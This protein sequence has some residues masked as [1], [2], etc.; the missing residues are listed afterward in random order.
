M[1][2]DSRLTTRREDGTESY[3]DDF[4]KWTN[5]NSKLIVIASGNARLAC[6]LIGQIIG[7]LNS[8]ST[9]SDL[10]DILDNQLPVMAK[11]YY[12]RYGDG[13]ADTAG[14]IFGG[15]DSTK[16]LQVDAARLGDVMSKTVIAAGEGNQV[17]LYA[18]PDVLKALTDTMEKAKKMGAQ[19]GRGWMITVDT[20]KPVIKAIDIKA[21]PSDSSG[22]DI[23]TTEISCYESISFHPNYKTER[24]LTPDEVLS[25]VDFP[26]D[27]ASGE[28]GMKVLGKESEVMI[29]F[30]NKIA[31]ERGYPSVGGNFVPIAITPLGFS[32]LVTGPLYRRLSDGSS[33]FVGGY[34]VVDGKLNYYET[35][36]KLVPY[37]H[38]IDYLEEYSDASGSAA[39][40]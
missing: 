3:V 17:Q 7:Q 9:F 37:R 16:K 13:L 25:Q 15:F 35:P 30:S 33:E 26:I 19:P 21:D 10:D 29:N 27:S 4:A 6:T 22:V 18:D 38:L 23:E 34:D 12:A 36:D 40:F 14:L 8:K 39:S 11:A 32:G 28:D 2:S 31:A 5:L 24:I 1:V 20:P